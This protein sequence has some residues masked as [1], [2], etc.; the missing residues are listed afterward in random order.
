MIKKNLTKSAM[1][2]TSI[3]LVVTIIAVAL[4]S[5]SFAIWQRK[6]STYKELEVPPIDSNPSLKH[7]MFSGLDINGNFT[8]VSGETVA[9]ALVGMNGLVAEVT[10]P[11][12]HLDKPVTKIATDPSKIEYEFSNNEIIQSIIIPESVTMIA[13]GVFQAM[14]NLVSVTVL[15][16]TEADTL[17]IGEM[18]FAYC[19]RL[20]VFICSRNLSA[21]E[22][23]TAGTPLG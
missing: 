10:I 3:L 13:A 12:E 16:D 22:S 23:Y 20:S 6:V 15:G 4:A 17:E 18:A 19:V 9:Y 2:I 8:S 5:T 11:G 7:L 14:P 1:L 21:H